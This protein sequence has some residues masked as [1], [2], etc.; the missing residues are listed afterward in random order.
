MSFQEKF[1][2][3]IKILLSPEGTSLFLVFLI[4]IF[5]WL[6]WLLHGDGWQYPE[7]ETEANFLLKLRND[8]ST[9]EIDKIAKKAIKDE[10]KRMKSIKEETNA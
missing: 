10:K 3:Y 7:N 8:P 5:A 4:L 1:V 6:Y 9:G 2:Y